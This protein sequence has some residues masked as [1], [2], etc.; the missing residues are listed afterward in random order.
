MLFSHNKLVLW[1]LVV[2]NATMKKGT[3]SALRVAETGRLN[4]KAGCAKSA[5]GTFILPKVNVDPAIGAALG[6]PETQ[7]MP[8]IL[9]CL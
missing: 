5:T 9:P 2:I 3:F 7:R 4:V 1:E 8:L 6:Y